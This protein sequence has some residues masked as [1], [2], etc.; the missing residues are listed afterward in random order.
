MRVHLPAP[1]HGLMDPAL[2]RYTIRIRG[3][4]GAMV[5]FAAYLTSLELFVI[6]A[7]CRWCVTSAALITVIFLLSL[8]D[9]RRAPSS[10]A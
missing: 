9:L 8:R 7:I 10:G 6:H 1:Q 4:L 2:A 5:L 3:H